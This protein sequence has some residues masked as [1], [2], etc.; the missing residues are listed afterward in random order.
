MK[1]TALRM[2]CRSCKNMKTC[3]NT[4]FIIVVVMFNGILGVPLSLRKYFDTI[5]AS[6]LFS[7]G[8]ATEQVV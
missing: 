2:Q 7:L 4:I 1:N 6:V 3:F 8:Q 5:I